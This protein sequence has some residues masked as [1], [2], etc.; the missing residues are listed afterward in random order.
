MTS[1]PRA[2]DRWHRPGLWVLRVAVALAAAVYLFQAVSAGQFLDG[3]YAFLRVHQLGTT[4]ADALM[5]LALA[6][7][8]CIKWIAR[9]PLTPFLAVLGAILVS[10]AQAAAGA[11]RLI[12]LHVPL[13]VVL[14]GVVWAVAWAAW[15]VPGWRGARR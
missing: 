6:S 3:D 7:T 14:I 12:W 11:A 9:G 15:T 2:R 10:Q 13:G 8:G 5:F 1:P 4:I